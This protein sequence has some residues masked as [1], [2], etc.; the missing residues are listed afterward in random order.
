MMS[1]VYAC[2]SRVRRGASA[3]LTHTN[4]HLSCWHTPSRP[5]APRRARPHPL[6]QLDSEPPTECASLRLIYSCK[7]GF[8]DTWPA[9][10]NTATLQYSVAT[11]RNHA[12]K[13]CKRNHFSVEGTEVRLPRG[14]S[15]MV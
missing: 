15:T 8:S 4:S 3:H 12:C 14:S 10:S 9:A 6:L 1:E 5:P 7:P 11:Y 13:R 2:T